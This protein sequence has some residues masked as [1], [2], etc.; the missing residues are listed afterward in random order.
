MKTLK[1]KIVM[2]IIFLSLIFLF[3]LSILEQ[4]LSVALL[5]L[6]IEN[7]ATGL[8]III[9]VVVMILTVLIMGFFKDKFIHLVY[10]T[11]TLLFI[12][13]ITL[14]LYFNN[15]TTGFGIIAIVI[16]LSVWG[17]TLWFIVGVLIKLLYSYFFKKDIKEVI[18]SLLKVKI[19]KS[20]LLSVTFTFVL[21]QLFLMGSSI[22][23]YKTVKVLNLKENIEY[24]VFSFYRPFNHEIRLRNGMRWSYGRVKFVHDGN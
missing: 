16:V 17:S 2:G 9:P 5:K 20:I 22:V 4:S 18:A 13:N 21:W 15:T 14:L 23:A 7:V 8:W 12:S 10:V 19:I 6:V 1:T 3:M 24:S 11:I